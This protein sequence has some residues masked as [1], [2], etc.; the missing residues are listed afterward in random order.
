LDAEGSETSGIDTDNNTASTEGNEPARMDAEGVQGA[1]EWNKVGGIF[2]EEKRHWNS[3]G[4]EVGAPREEGVTL[5]FG[6]LDAVADDP[7][8]RPG[9]P[10]TDALRD[11]ASEVLALGNALPRVRCGRDWEDSPSGLNCATVTV[12]AA[13]PLP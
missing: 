5:G 11:A 6:A 12:C 2:T 9:R 7:A 13:A 8:T 1:I 3:T 4:T 10:L